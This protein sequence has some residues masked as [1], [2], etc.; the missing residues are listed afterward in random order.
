[1]RNTTGCARHRRGNR[2]S[3]RNCGK[4]SCRAAVVP[5]QPAESSVTVDFRRRRQGNRSRWVT[6]Q[7]TIVLPLV[8]P[9]RVVPIDVFRDDMP[10]V[11]FAEQ[12]E[13]IRHSRR[14]DCTHRSANA[15][16][17]GARGPTGFATI[18]SCLRIVS[19]CEVNFASKSRIRCV[20][21]TGSSPSN[22]HS[23]LADR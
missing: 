15:F 22:A 5:Q 23:C 1:V 18:P 20:G 14:I 10:Q 12:D 4:S 9:N 8:R 6:G 19:N 7:R 16:R 2:R 13:M 3:A 21:L 11:L 17:F